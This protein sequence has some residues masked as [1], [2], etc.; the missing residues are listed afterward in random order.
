MNKTSLITILAILALSTGC[1]NCVNQSIHGNGKAVV[2][3]AD[4]KAVVI[5][6]KQP[7]KKTAA[8]TE[9]YILVSK[10]TEVVSSTP[11]LF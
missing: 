7:L 8:D 10:T 5:P 2:I 6:N 11:I 9:D 3:K 1:V 4:S